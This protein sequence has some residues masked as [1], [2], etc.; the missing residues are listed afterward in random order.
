MWIPTS[1]LVTRT[2]QLSTPGPRRL[3]HQPT[4]LS[5]GTNRDRSPDG[6]CSIGGSYVA[7]LKS[8]PGI[9]MWTRVSLPADIQS[10]A[11]SCLNA[12]RRRS[13]TTIAGLPPRIATRQSQQDQTP[14]TV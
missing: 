2:A 12:S 5:D 1:A 8:S 7:L 11:L 3:G 6:A 13:T 4:R 14:I 9:G 10:M